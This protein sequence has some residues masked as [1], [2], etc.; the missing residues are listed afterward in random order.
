MPRSYSEKSVGH[1]EAKDAVAGE[2]PIAI[3]GVACRLPGAADPQALWSLLSEGRTGIRPLTS[4]RF[5]LRDFWHP[6]RGEPGKFYATHAGTLENIEGFDAGFFGISPREAKQ[7]DPQQRLLLELAWEALEDAG[8]RT[9]DLSNAG[10]YVG[11][12]ANEY[13]NVR[14]GDPAS[15]D[16]YFMPGNTLSIF[17]NRIS[18]A[19]D[20]HGP[21]FT[22]DTA[23]SSSIVALHLACEDLRRGRIEAAFVGGVNML[24]SPYPFIGFCS[25]DM[26]SASGECRTFDASA[27]GYVR[28]EGGV[29]V[30]LKPLSAAQRDGD[31]IHALILGTGTNSDGRTPGL[32]FPSMQSQADLLREVYARAGVRPEELAFVEA[33][34]TGT[35]AGDPVEA[36]ALGTVLGRARAEPLPIGSVKTNLGHLEPA[37]GLAGLLKAVLA[38]QKRELPPSLHF[39]T[40]NPA[41]AFTD[42]NLVVADRALPLGNGRLVAGVNNFGF[43]GSNAHVIVASAPQAAVSK[44]VGD[45]PPLLLSARTQPALRALAGAWAT[46]S[47]DAPALRGLV[48]R[49]NH[50]SYRLGVAAGDEVSMREALAA[51]AAG[52]PHAAVVEGRILREAR[53]AFVFSGNG[54]QFATMGSDILALS[55]AFYEGV[56]AADAALRPHL[57]WS[58]METMRAGTCVIDQAESAQPLLFALQVGSAWALRAQGVVAEAVVGH[59]VGEIAAAYWSGA[60]PLEEAARIVVLRS[61][62]QERA[63][64]GGMAALSCSAERAAALIAPIASDLAVA[65]VNAPQAVTVAGQPASLD[66]LAIVAAKEGLAF[67]RLDIAYAFHSAAMAPVEAPLIADL[68]NVDWSIPGIPMISTVTGKLVTKLDADYWWH[69]VREPVLFAPAVE[70]LARFGSRI[71]VEIGPRPVLQFYLRETLR[72]GEAECRA[73][74]TLKRAVAASDP[75]PRI[76]LGIHV[77]GGDISPAAA[78][79]GPVR[80]HGLPLIQWQREPH[81]YTATDEALQTL[82]KRAP[83]HPVLGTRVDD[84]AREWIA[85]LDTQR[86][87]WLADHVVGN[88]PTLAAAC[89]I[90]FAMTAAHA[91]FPAANILELQDFEIYRPVIL[92]AAQL[93]E[94]RVRLEDGLVT[95]DSRPRLSGTPWVHHAQGRIGLSPVLPV[96]KVVETSSLSGTLAGEALYLQA[97]ALGLQYG[98]RFKRVA[99]AKLYGQAFVDADLTA[100][101]SQENAGLMLDPGALDGAFQILIALGTQLENSAYQGAPLPR[102][103]GRLR[104]D[105]NAAAAASAQAFIT[106]AGPREIGA[107]VALLD[108]A[109]ETILSAEACWFTRMPIEVPLPVGERSFH[110][111][112]RRA[113]LTSPIWAEE[114]FIAMRPVLIAESAGTEAD[115]DA[116]T[117]AEIFLQ[118]A[119]EEALGGSAAIGAAAEAAPITAAAQALLAEPSK[120]EKLPESSRIWQTLFLD[121]PEWMPAA[122]IL[123]WM[124]DQLRLR[125]AQEA[126]GESATE[127]PAAPAA[128]LEQLLSGRLADLSAGLL[129]EAVSAFAR[130]WPTDRPLR[131]LEV[132]SDRA[133]LTR[134]LVPLLRPLTA[135]LDYSLVEANAERLGR[136]RPVLREQQPE[137]A[138]VQEVADKSQDIIVAFGCGMR[139]LTPAQILAYAPALVEGGIM[140]VV[141]A[142]EAWS[143]SWL[144][145]LSGTPLSGVTAWSDLPHQL[146]AVVV[147][148]S[149]ATPFPVALLAA[150][151][152]DLIGT[153]S[154][155]SETSDD[156]MVLTDGDQQSETHLSVA[157]PRITSVD[158]AEEVKAVGEAIL[159]LVRTASA[160]A[161]SGGRLVVVTRGAD[162]DPIE[163]ARFALARVIA[164]EYPGLGCR[165]IEISPDVP[166]VLATAHIEAELTA[167]TPETEVRWTAAGRFVRRLREGLPPS[168]LPTVPATRRLV[169]A[170]PGPLTRLRWIDICE[171]PL[172]PEDVAI[173]V[174]ATGIN[175]RDIMQALG[176]LPDEALLEGFAGAT[177]GMECAGVVAEVGPAVT[178][179]NPG[180]R[181]MAFASAAHST[182][183]VTHKQGVLPLPDALSF[184]DGA[185]IPVA[186][187]T[188]LYAMET[189][190]DLQPGET[191]LIHGAAGGVGLA[192]MQLAHHL[193]ARV[194]ATAGSSAKRAILRRLGAEAVLDSRSLRFSMEVERATNGQGIDVVIN[195]LAGEAMERSLALLKPFG[196]FIELGKR[197]FFS[198]TRV[199]LRPLRRNI[200]YYGVDVDSLLGH[201]PDI[202]L[203]LKARLVQLFR[204]EALRPLPRLAL[205]FSQAAEAFMAMRAS[206]HVGK[207]VLTAGPLPPVDHVVLR[208]DQ[209]FVVSGGT[210]GFGA[211]AGRWL[212][213]AGARHLLLLSRRGADAPGSLSLRERLLQAGAETVEIAACDVA[214]RAALGAVLTEARRLRP[215]GGVVHAATIIADGLLASLTPTQVE[216]SLHAKLGGALA[217]D[218][219][220]R[221]DPLSL[222]LVFSSATVTLGAPGQGAYVAANAA[223]EAMVTRRRRAGLPGV[224]VRWGPIRDAGFLAGSD[225]VR[226]AL[227][228]RLGARA[229][230]AAQALEALPTLL[231]SD[232]DQPV[233]A[234]VNWTAVGLPILAEPLFLSIFRTPEAHEGKGDIAAFLAGRSEEERSHILGEL[235][236]DELARI[237]QAD[238]TSLDL[239]MPLADLGMDSLTAVELVLSLERRLA[240]TLPSFAWQEMTVQRIARQ[241]A[242]IVQSGG[243]TSHSAPPIKAVS[244]R[245]LPEQ[246]AA[247]LVAVAQASL[248]SEAAQ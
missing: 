247:R 179:I 158:P 180:D 156:T 165:R 225:A 19:L 74:P 211:E 126:N 119:V 111:I 10:V 199:G 44:E 4:E 215:I 67:Q 42:L 3:V 138:L 37:S 79:S 197:D 147:G 1:S 201:R 31:D 127:I 248:Q 77:L 237:I 153:G 68:G 206:T 36:T 53:V 185:T 209:T 170:Q 60:L 222:F 26:L 141:E 59:S 223:V 130:D 103:F 146:S 113:P 102:R 148:K 226:E 107:D 235:I 7:I 82:W 8:L 227:G 196:R 193:G 178:E 167:A 48:R 17:A 15:G 174:H 213:S 228:R 159:A 188:A 71:F 18:Y 85:H 124:D 203:R 120:K 63:R 6:R 29:M 98:K 23:C 231:R 219:L 234:E 99:R 40:P 27:D 131:V 245:H 88:T 232:T 20:L 238:R 116:A 115:Q 189:L 192:A 208:G 135:E 123:A 190:A 5:P 28:A 64:G 217:L 51:A 122:T 112:W 152:A 89:L 168:A 32:S 110:E 133:V 39:K 61:R 246:E 21:S 240:V 207:I 169:Q 204:E 100:V 105:L 150:K 55:P 161:E 92:E 22:V 35:A 106:V 242:G 65:A 117:L 86:H 81:W 16:A 136:L 214:D 210:A 171:E 176:M 163:A 34:G 11:A 50:H 191:I 114:R 46:H 54:T 25:A 181:V 205:P 45:L 186:Y 9:G 220:T 104:L 38:L 76:A 143:W 162:I 56:A 198:N 243:Q 218:A 157:P 172:G 241:L 221:A 62:H 175:F 101:D 72:G 73:V 151:P 129:A 97:A 47:W 139:G 134:R 187:L 80:S 216:A 84:E 121:S 58:V 83:G 154:V 145:K 109:G 195:S 90:E 202:V 239:N 14:F 13:A 125:V 66:A 166:Q 128:P 160:V 137:V 57:S 233:L 173:D 52:L 194:I 149:T 69:N 244:A 108:E 49:R 91:A 94:L 43:G 184:V 2:E 155:Q 212:L 177:L 118:A 95:I 229:M 132:Y 93:R 200:S 30:L 87:P 70:E 140:L 182:R 224:A 24:L 164:N 12:S 144:R 75:F 142:A 96:A 230:P 183:I 33:H 236:I 41:I 78:F